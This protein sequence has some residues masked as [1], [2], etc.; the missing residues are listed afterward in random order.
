MNKPLYQ[1]FE[2]DHL[3]IEALLNKAL[4]QPNEIAMEYY[5]Q[6]R[7]R[8]LKHIKMEENILFPAAKKANPELILKII[9]RFRLDH[10]AITSLLVPPPTLS[11]IKVLRYI[12]DKHNIAEEEDGGLYQICETLTHEHTQELLS[13]LLE[14][15]EVPVHPP[16]PAPIA[17]EAAKRALARA[18]YDFDEL[19]R[20]TN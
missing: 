11:T 8:L 20:L 19:I 7:T 12:L 6:F 18:G 2:K 16:N 15:K 17:I 4:D 10:G 3:E 1:F 9:P 13:K 5:L 14:T